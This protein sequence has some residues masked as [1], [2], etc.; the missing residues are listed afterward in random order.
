MTRKDKTQ[1]AMEL[2]KLKSI[3]QDTGN[4]DLMNKLEQSASKTELLKTVDFAVKSLQTQI[5]NLTLSVPEKIVNSLLGKR[6]AVH[7]NLNPTT[8]PTAKKFDFSVISRKFT[9]LLRGEG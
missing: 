3:L 8:Q 2:K 5:D 9:Q 1:I 6:P 4:S 7:F